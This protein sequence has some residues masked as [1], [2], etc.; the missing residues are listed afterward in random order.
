V[1][2]GEKKMYFSLRFEDGI[3]M[4]ACQAQ[5]TKPHQGALC[6][7]TRCALFA[8][9]KPKNRKTG[10]QEKMKQEESDSGDDTALFGVSLASLANAIVEYQLD[11]SRGGLYCRKHH[12]ACDS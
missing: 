3:L 12:L 8:I 5:S 10:D 6:R 11:L 4:L 9:F 1:E 7:F 2:K